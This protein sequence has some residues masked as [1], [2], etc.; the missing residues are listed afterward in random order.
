M[1]P[2]DEVCLILV[3][4]HGEDEPDDRVMRL[5]VA[6]ADRSGVELGQWLGLRH[7]GDGP[8][9]HVFLGYR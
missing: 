4:A 2:D 8:T 1:L 7:V 9:C 6:E 5:A 3:V